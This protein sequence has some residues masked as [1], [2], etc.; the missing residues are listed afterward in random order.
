MSTLPLASLIIRA[1]QGPDAG[2]DILLLLAEEA[3]RVAGRLPASQASAWQR[4]ARLC[5]DMAP[6]FAAAEPASLATH[7]APPPAAEAMSEREAAC[8]AMLRAY[9]GWLPSDFGAE[10]ESTTGLSRALLRDLHA[11]AKRN[12][13]R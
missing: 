7:A 10:A 5:R 9:P 11:A 12:W 1:V 6:L 8:A 3:D 13:G 2:S 4:S